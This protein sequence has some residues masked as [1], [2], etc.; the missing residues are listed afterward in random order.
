MD[1]NSFLFHPDPHFS[2]FHRPQDE[3]MLAPYWEAA[4]VGRSGGTRDGRCAGLYP[5]CPFSVLDIF[6][7]T[8]K[9][10]NM[11]KAK[12]REEDS[13]YRKKDTNNRKESRRSK[14]NKKIG[15]NSVGNGREDCDDGNDNGEAENGDFDARLT[16]KSPPAISSAYSSSTTSSS[17]SPPPQSK[18]VIVL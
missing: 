9:D 16:T 3:E 6:R 17:S 4:Q 18:N 2:P 12:E 8:R 5:G 10:K 1:T 11:K 13:E 15:K 7:L 14:E